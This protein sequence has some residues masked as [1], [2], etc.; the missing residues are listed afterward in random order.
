MAA[1]AP[2]DTTKKLRRVKRSTLIA[3]LRRSGTTTGPGVAGALRPGR[4]A[5]RAPCANTSLRREQAPYRIARP[6]AHGMAE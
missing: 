2:V 4:V 3:A 6:L 1:S 5:D